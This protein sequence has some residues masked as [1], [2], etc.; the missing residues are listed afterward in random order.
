MLSARLMIAKGLA[1][2]VGNNVQ[3]ERSDGKEVVRN[4]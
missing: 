3:V 1:K 2:Q 4:L